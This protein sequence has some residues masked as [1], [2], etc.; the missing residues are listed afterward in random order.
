MRH[1][2]KAALVL[3]L[4]AVS[5]SL[6][7]A[8]AATAAPARVGAKTTVGVTAGKPSEL[9]FKLTKLRVPKGT[10][11]FRIKNQGALQHDFKIKG[12]MTARLMP[13]QT[14]TLVVRFAKAGRFQFLCTVPGHATAGMKGRLTVR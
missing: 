11:T 6:V 13:G 2:R 10:V 12:K 3:A 8:G 1:G 7:A 5:V 4:G 14:A 9:K